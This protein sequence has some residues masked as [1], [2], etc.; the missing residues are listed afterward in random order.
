MG[1]WGGPGAGSSGVEHGD[2]PGDMFER[3]CPGRGCGTTAGGFDH[4]TAIAEVDEVGEQAPVVADRGAQQC[5]RRGGPVGNSHGAPT[6]WRGVDIHDALADFTERAGGADEGVDVGG[7]PL[8]DLGGDVY[9]IVHDDDDPDVAPASAPGRSAPAMRCGWS[10]GTSS[11][12]WAAAASIRVVGSVVSVLIGFLL[13]LSGDLT[14][15]FGAGFRGPRP[16]DEATD[17]QDGRTAL[18]LPCPG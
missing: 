18:Q 15:G 16:A 8:L 12:D 1:P 5:N 13:Y 6:R 4:Q 2:V 9:A 3:L 11:E 10:A 17:G 7:V 14:E